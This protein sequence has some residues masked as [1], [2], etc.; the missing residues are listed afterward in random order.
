MIDG[1]RVHRE[2]VQ[3][4]TI[5]QLLPRV[6]TSACQT[7]CQSIPWPSRHHEVHTTA[8]HKQSYRTHEVTRQ[9]NPFLLLLLLLLSMSLSFCQP[10]FLFL[11][12]F[13]LLAYCSLMG[14]TC[15]AEITRIRRAPLSSKPGTCAFFGRVHGRGIIDRLGGAREIRVCRS[16]EPAE[17]GGH[18]WCNT[19]SRRPTPKVSGGD[20]NG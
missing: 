11:F 19:A 9:D 13:L 7:T 1:I 3:Q 12:L 20:V 4:Q 8:E 5:P 10:L 17:K 14:K 18:M 16:K 15:I 2:R 6:R